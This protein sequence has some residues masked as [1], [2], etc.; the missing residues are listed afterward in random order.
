[1]HGLDQILHPT[2]F[3]EGAASAFVHAVRLARRNDAILH[4]LNV[5][6]DLGED[7]IGGAYGQRVDEQAYLQELK[8]ETDAEMQ[9]LVDAVDTEGVRIKRVHS[10]G[11]APGPVITDYAEQEDIDLIAVGTTGRRGMR[12]F[13]LG[14]VAEEVVR[15][16]PCSVFTVRSPHGVEEEPDLIQRLL[17]PL[18]LSAYTR[19]LLRTGYE[20]AAEYSAAV[21]LLHVVDAS[22]YPKPL[23]GAFTLRD[24]VDD[25]ERR[26]EGQMDHLIESLA[27]DAI[28]TERYVREGHPASQIVAA[29]EEHDV[30]LI[31]IASH[32][33]SGFEGFLVGSVTERVV[34][35]ASC[36]VFVARVEPEAPDDQDEASAP[37]E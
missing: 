12:R 36:P 18:D 30:D 2:D 9:Q 14:S 4:L 15:R 1:M 29:A 5:A 37:E 19:P 13:V 34:R 31:V 17:I 23:V 10:R 27:P 6:P 3:S 11:V 33:R 25:P 24:V 16:A 21:D 32:G 22:P 26:A 20:V 7:P 35:R 8:A 28:P